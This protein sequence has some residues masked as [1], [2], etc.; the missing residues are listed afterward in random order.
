M[1]RLEGISCAK[2]HHWTVRGVVVAEGTV[3]HCM[4]NMTNPATAQQLA[5]ICSIATAGACKLTNS[6]S[7]R[8]FLLF[9]TV[10]QTQGP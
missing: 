10:N 7:W 3:V 8:G 6:V 9:K 4:S 1:V 2:L 5:D